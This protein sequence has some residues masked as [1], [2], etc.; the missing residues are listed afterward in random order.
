MRLYHLFFKRK[1]K[2]YVSTDKNY[3]IAERNCEPLCLKLTTN[4]NNVA[5]TKNREIKNHLYKKV[6]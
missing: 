1:L 3:I 4:Y 2:N 6:Q 5:S